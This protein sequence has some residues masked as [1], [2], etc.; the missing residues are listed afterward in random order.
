[1]Y[2]Q[3]V[4]GW[5]LGDS[6]EEWKF[7][8]AL[9]ALGN[10]YR[11]LGQYTQAIDYHQQS[12]A[13]PRESGA[14]RGEAI[15]WF[16]S[17]LALEQLGRESDALSAYRNTHELYQAMGLDAD[18]QD[19]DN[20]IQRLEEVGLAAEVSIPVAQRNPQPTLWKICPKL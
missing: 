11:A 6:Y 17:G 5:E 12:Q 18:V 9:S 2:S 4:Q 15:T 1:M 7:G 16:N 20:A 14:R 10:A 3:L 19:C 13:I 8:A